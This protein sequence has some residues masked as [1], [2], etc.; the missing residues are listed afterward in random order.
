MEEEYKMTPF[1]IIATTNINL[2]QGPG[3]SFEVVEKVPLGYTM[4]AL[5]MRKD[6]GG[7]T[8]YETDLNKAW[9]KST[10]VAQPNEINM[11]PLRR[12]TQSK[13]K[14]VH[15]E[16]EAITTKTSSS[17]K[18]PFMQVA[19]S[20]AKAANINLGVLGSLIGIDSGGSQDTILK[21]RI[22]ATPYQFLE[23]ADMRP[24]D[25]PLGLAFVQNIMCESPILSILPGI[26]N[27]LSEMDTEEKKKIIQKLVDTINKDI[28][29]LKDHEGGSL[30]EANADM[31]FFDFEPR[32]ADYF[33][34]V[35]VLCRMAA[36]FM[37]IGDRTVPGGAP[38]DAAR[39]ALREGGGSKYAEYNWF[40]YHLSNVY[41]ETNTNPTGIMEFGADLIKGGIKKVTEAATNAAKGMVSSLGSILGGESSN[42]GQAAVDATPEG[43]GTGG[44]SNGIMNTMAGNY[45]Y[46]DEYFINFFVKPPS[47]SESFSN[48]TDR[49]AFANALQGMSGTMKEFMFLFGGLGVDTKL[50]T[51]N[52]ESV[53]KNMETAIKSALDNAG[54][55]KALSSFI[56]GATSVITGANLIFPEIWETSSYNRDFNIDIQLTSPYG[57]R[58]SIYLNIVVPLMHLL[59]LVLPRQATVNSYTAPFLVRCSLPGYFSC[60]MGIVKELSISKGGSDGTAWSADGFPTE[61]NVSM[62]ISDLYNALSMSNVHTA[63][64][65]WNFLYN[66]PLMDYV[67][68]LCGLNMRTSEYGKKIQLIEFLLGNAGLDHYDYTMNRGR[69]WSAQSQIKILAGKG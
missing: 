55:K 15:A 7:V 18:S 28:S 5:S 66:G 49:S 46:M 29:L 65:A 6:G 20:I 36:V 57:D 9:V 19:N 23:T 58:E 13:I 69:E 51:E 1:P 33:L 32:C 40:Y 30:S 63:R 39:V 10:Y 21:R 42:S 16:G 31:K 24:D 35:N 62:S 59:A 17:G 41:T 26:P 2:R 68:V 14:N 52:A 47:Y 8:W 45:F 43:S 44:G 25:G 60:D 50:M 67:G 27:P 53:A 4:K 37:G 56:T 34:Y 48:T 38:Q 12:T 3:E 22:Y 11:K 64:N 54:M 61:V